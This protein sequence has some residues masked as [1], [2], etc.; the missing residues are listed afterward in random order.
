[1]APDGVITDVAIARPSGVTGFDAAVIRDAGAW[2][3]VLYAAPAGLRVCQPLTV[4]FR[5]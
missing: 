1:M 2:Q 5:P 3:F 4:T